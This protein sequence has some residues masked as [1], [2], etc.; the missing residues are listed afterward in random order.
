[1]ESLRV[2]LFEEKVVDFILE[3][4]DVKE[5]KVSVDELTAE[6]EDDAPK[7]KSTAKKADDKKD[8]KPAAKKKAPAKKKTAAKK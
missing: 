5:K 7:K 3:L 8:D 4:A 6:I 1:M 2:P